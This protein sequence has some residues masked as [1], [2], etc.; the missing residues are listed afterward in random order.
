MSACVQLATYFAF[1]QLPF[2][3]GTLVV[4]TASATPA[5]TL[6]ALR[7]HLRALDPDV[8]LEDVRRLSAVLDQVVLI[9]AATMRIMVAFAGVALLLTALGLYSVLAHRVA[10]R[11]REIAVRRALGAPGGALVTG[12]ASETLL[13]ALAGLLAGYLLSL[14]TAR[15]LEPFAFQVGVIDARSYLLAGAMLLGMAAAA[16]AIPLRRALRIEPA[17]ALRE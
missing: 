8:P 5:A 15:L 17:R 12:V 14:M 16:A 2:A 6:D 3:F 4:R 7:Q 1:D 9:P 10:Q 11:T 13:T